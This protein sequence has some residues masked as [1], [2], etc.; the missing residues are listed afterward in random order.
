LL[1]LQLLTPA[2]ADAFLRRCPEEQVQ[3][4][5]P[6]PLGRA[7]AA[8]GLL[9][10]YQVDRVLAGTTHGLVL[11]NYRVLDRLGAGG[12]GVVFLAEHLL[13]K[14]R[15]AVKV[16]PLDEDGPPAL[17]ERF[18]QEMCVLADLHH[19]HLILT[20]DAGEVAPA[21]PGNP[22]L[23]FLVM[24][25]L[26]GGDLEAHVLDHGLPS[27]AQA[28]EWIRQAAC[29]LQVAHDHHL[30]HRDIK[31][32]NLLLTVHG[33]VKLV[34]FG[35]ARQF[36]S[37]LTDPRVT[38]GSLEFMPPEQSR[39]PSEVG[40]EADIYGLGATLF[41]LLTGQPPY[42]RARN[43]GEALRALQ[44]RPPRRLRE[45][46]SDLP[47]ELEQ[48]V[49]RMV[50]AD[51]TQRPALPLAVMNA[52]LPFAVEHAIAAADSVPASPF[53]Q[54]QRVLIVDDEPS[55]RHYIRCTLEA[56]GYVCDEAADA[57][58]CLAA[59]RAQAYDL[60]LLDLDLPDLD[61]R[62]VCRRLRLSS[63]SLNLRII[64]VSGQGD[65]NQL[66]SVLADG[67][68]DYV[69]KPFE[70]PQLRA[71]VQHALQL[72][73]ALDH[74]DMLMEQLQLTNA[75]LQ[76]S[77]QA[78]ADDVC[79]V[80]DA[81]LFAIARMAESRDGETPEHLR[82]LQ[83]YTRCLAEE[84]GR[85]PSWAGQVDA[86]FLE[87]LERCV[88]LH[89]IGK[90]GLPDQVLCKPGALDA[91]ERALVETHPLIGDRL[92][93]ALGQEHGKSLTFLRM[94]SAIVRH[95]HER[96]DGR[97]YPDGLRGAIIPPAAR[98][99]AVADVYDALR[100]ERP[101]K[102][103]L[104]HDAACRILLEQSSGQFDPD[105]LRAF[106]ACHAQFQQI[107]E[108]VRERTLQRADG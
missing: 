14:R 57:G 5:Q 90:I 15:A 20:F 34:D 74:T 104:S 62:E 84:A 48:L 63:L 86:R 76:Q 13:M 24:E 99:V 100:R 54:P 70:P 75:Q 17:R 61:G 35:L 8:A 52:L 107:Y 65:Q 25:V 19:P 60:V 12:M 22:G 43:M 21:G 9:T 71:K 6:E 96:Y 108:E 27:T 73:A 36:Q 30:I 81:L 64:V 41:W 59:A 10:D 39:D 3:S 46:R 92:L 45:L 50:H 66:A 53:S 98:L 68:D 58:A 101:H 103:A 33:Q 83:R 7:L 55:I 85:Q 51:P 29:G 97:G 2:G 44:S 69:P 79:A 80:Q 102:P 26:S 1:A 72:K 49:D 87:Q 67:A 88:P 94:A 18:Y 32:S 78:R 93:E 40:V 42:P 89:D 16:L 4:W 95:H 47:P 28:C 23:L 37:R 91:A 105:L 31:P 106:A 82:R 38:L 56:C 11:G 77:L